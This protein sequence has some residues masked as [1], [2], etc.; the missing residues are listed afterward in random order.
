MLLVFRDL[1]FEITS[2]IN[3]FSWSLL[4]RIV[5]FE[6]WTTSLMMG[7][8]MER[9]A[10]SEENQFSGRMQWLSSSEEPLW[11]NIRSRMEFA[12]PD[13]SEYLVGQGLVG[14]D[15]NRL[16]ESA[17]IN[18]SSLMVEWW[19]NEGSYKWSL[20]LKLPV[21]MRTLL[22]FTSVSLRYFKA[23]WEELEYTFKIKKHILSLKKE[24]RLM[25]LWLITSL[26]S[27]KQR[28]ERWMFT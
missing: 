18:K 25:S 17:I 20:I 13:V 14:L 27:K 12:S 11:K 24:I 26:W 10:W 3:A 15:K 7:I 16:N 22:I 28:G 19:G 6:N 9:G 2:S 4:G 23:V 8:S 1:K 21:I 5:N